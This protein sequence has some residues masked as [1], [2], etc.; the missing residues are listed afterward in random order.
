MGVRF[1]HR[2]NTDRPCGTPGAIYS[3]SM[4]EN[5]IRLGIKLPIVRR[6]NGVEKL[7]LAE[8]SEKQR[9]DLSA[10]LHNQIL[11]VM[12]DFYERL[13]PKVFANGRMASD[14]HPMPKEYCDLY[15]EKPT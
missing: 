10:N 1:P 9:K 11:L 13:W 5:S 7:P 3:T 14:P 15:A 12:E 4:T 6:P 2:D 8:L